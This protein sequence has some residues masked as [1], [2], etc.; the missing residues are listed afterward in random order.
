M[1][2]STFY[3]KYERKE[4]NKYIST[5]FD[6]MKK[7]V[8]TQTGATQIVE[9]KESRTKNRQSNFLVKKKKRRIRA[10]KLKKATNFMYE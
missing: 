8:S 2:P 7:V 1:R 6:K 4:Q 3:E 9:E 10:I 5:T